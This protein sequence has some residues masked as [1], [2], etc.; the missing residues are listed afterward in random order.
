MNKYTY[1]YTITLDDIAG[2][3]FRLVPLSVMG[4]MQDACA[5]YTAT[6]K[7]GPQDLQAQNRYWVIKEL[8]FDLATDLPSWGKEITI[9]C[10]FSEI[11]KLRVYIDFTVRWNQHI[12]A[13][14]YTLWLIVDK[15]TKRLIQTNEMAAR[16]PVC[17]DLV[18]GTHKKLILPALAEPYRSVTKVMDISD[19][20]FNGH[21]NNKSYLH[22]A[23]RSMGSEFAETHT[24]SHL[25]A[26][27]NQETYQGDVLTSSSYGT[28]LS[29]RFAH[30]IRKNTLPVCE[31]VTCWKEQMLF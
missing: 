30:L 3:S 14:G 31:I 19:K 15:Q 1:T 29:N 17:T 16:F 9:E 24:L 4:Y 25:H 23:L 6:Q 13:K 12:L 26:R 5:R 11:S 27:F 10:W 7:M 8:A 2:E 21:I 22:L 28:Y 20:D 18:L